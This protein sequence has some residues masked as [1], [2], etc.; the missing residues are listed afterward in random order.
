LNLNNKYA[1]EMKIVLPKLMVITEYDVR[2]SRLLTL[3][4]SG[5]GKLQGNFSKSN[6]I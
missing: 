4:I 3:D 5:K 6:I 1:A 2:G